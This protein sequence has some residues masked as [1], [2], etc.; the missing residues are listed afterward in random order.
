MQGLVD[1][2]FGF[3]AALV[4][5][6]LA[7]AV[8]R[9]H[10]WLLRSVA[11]A[12]SVLLLGAALLL[13]TEQ[14]RDLGSA[15]VAATSA[16]RLWFAAALL[17]WALATWHSARFPLDRAHAR[18][19]REPPAKPRHADGRQ[20]GER[21]R[22][23]TPRLLGG[24]VFVFALVHLGLAVRAGGDAADARILALIVLAVAI[25][26]ALFV[27]Y[28]RG[29]GRALHDR[30]ANRAPQFA[31]RLDAAFEPAAP[32]AGDERLTTAVATSTWT[33]FLLF[34]GIGLALTAMAWSDPLAVG[35]RFGSMALG[36]VALGG[37]LSGLV[38]LWMV[39][40][41]LGWRLPLAV[42]ALLLAALAVS[43][44][45]HYHPARDCSELD[46][47]LA[48][49]ALEGARPDVAAAAVD[50][51]EQARATGLVAEDAPVPMLIVATAGGGLRA[52]YWT[53]VVLGTLPEELG[54]DLADLR[55]PLLRHQ[56]RLRRQCRRGVPHGDAA[57]PR[58][59]AKP[60]SG[61]A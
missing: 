11:P 42:G 28:R 27:V 16:Q 34:L 20:R 41:R 18:W 30:L 43:L 13:G 1:W 4:V 19:L 48:G 23:W 7:V 33:A 47:C 15:L 58:R 53:A 37:L 26:Y 35:D 38:A 3:L 40:E 60:R 5:V 36:F 12:A 51:Y 55:A 14:G 57:R 50:W 21:R 59:C 10:R 39:S 52:A 17:Y 9:S 56:R 6:W 61:R 22:R 29:A 45:R 32:P 25:L 49:D 46:G 24:L 2:A 44:T 8:Y 54:L 31:V